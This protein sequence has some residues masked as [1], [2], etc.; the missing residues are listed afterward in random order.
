MLEEYELHDIELEELQ[1]LFGE[2]PADR[3]YHSYDVSET[4]KSRLEDAASVQIDLTNYDYCIDTNA[5]GERD[6]DDLTDPN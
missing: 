4:Q 2:T 5:I 6:T 3:M 1:M